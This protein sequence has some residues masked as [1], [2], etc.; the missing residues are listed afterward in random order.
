MTNSR[1]SVQFS[2]HFF[3]SDKCVGTYKIQNM[4][5]CQRKPACSQQFLKKDGIPQLNKWFCSEECLE[6]DADHDM[7]YKSVGSAL[8]EQ[9]GGDGISGLNSEDDEAFEIDL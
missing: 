8:K 5:G 9:L 4:I 6:Q 3:C 2:E 7:F 1:E